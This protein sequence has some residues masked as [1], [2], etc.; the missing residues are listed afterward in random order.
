MT[1]RGKTIISKNDKIKK[2]ILRTVEIHQQILCPSEKGKLNI[3]E[4]I[5]NNFL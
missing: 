4:Y 2:Y 5:F 3:L 1:D